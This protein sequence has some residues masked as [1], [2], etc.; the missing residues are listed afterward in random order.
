MKCPDKC[1][2]LCS[3]NKTVCVCLTRGR[4]VRGP[5]TIHVSCACMLQKSVQ[6]YESGEI[7]AVLNSQL[8]QDGSYQI[9]PE[10]LTPLKVLLWG[11]VWDILVWVC[12][13]WFLEGTHVLEPQRKGKEML[14]SP[15]WMS[16]GRDCGEGSSKVL[17]I[18]DPLVTEGNLCRQ[19]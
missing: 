13:G 17:M 6:A 12:L 15:L 14:I 10:R 8:Y 2:R 11:A 7:E 9:S 5:L 1:F 18:L 16:S 3:R 4:S 19:L